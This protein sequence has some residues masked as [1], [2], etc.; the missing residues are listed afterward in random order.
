MA[1]VSW[2]YTQCYAELEQIGENR[3]KTIHSKLPDLVNG[4]REEEKEEQVMACLAVR[5]DDNV[6]E[7]GGNIGRLSTVIGYI[8]KESGSLWVVEPDSRHVESAILNRDNAGMDYFIFNGSISKRPIQCL[9]WPPESI[10]QSSNNVSFKDF[11]SRFC[12]NKT[13]T[14]LACDCE[15]ALF[16][17]LFDEP[18]MLDDIQTV[19]LENDFP[20]TPYLSETFLRRGFQNDFPGINR[21]EWVHDLLKAKGFRTVYQKELLNFQEDFY[22]V[23]TKRA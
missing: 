18:S 22:Q 2:I 9:G 3:L 1:P 4:S 19:I 7:L 12:C 6:L 15:G 13:I 20:D 5:P 17:T 16:Y 11:Q 14:V 23:W 10:F 8:T 21:K